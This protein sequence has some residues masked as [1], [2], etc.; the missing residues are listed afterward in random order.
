MSGHSNGFD[1]AEVNARPDSP[2]KPGPK[3]FIF[4]YL[5]YLPWVLVTLVFFMILAYL[6][7]RYATSIYRVQ[8]S[9]LIKNDRSENRASDARFDELFMSQGVTNLSNEIEILKSKPVLQR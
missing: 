8:S 1:P 5:K 3:E 6:K 4:R 2:W 7:V 9:L